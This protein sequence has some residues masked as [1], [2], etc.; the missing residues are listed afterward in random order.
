MRSS[1]PHFVRAQDD[2]LKN[3]LDGIFWI[4]LHATCVA[5]DEDENKYPPHPN[6]FPLGETKKREQWKK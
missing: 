5:P 3:S 6:T 1:R 4:D 2:R